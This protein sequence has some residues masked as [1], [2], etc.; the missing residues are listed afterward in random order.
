QRSPPQEISGDLTTDARG[1]ANISVPTD[2][3]DYERYL[4]LQVDARDESGR[5][6]SVQSSVDVEP[7]TFAV[8]LVPRTWFGEVNLPSTVDVSATRYDRRPQ[9]PT[10]VHVRILELH[11]DRGWDAKTTDRGS[12]DV[13][14]GSAG[15]ASFV[16]TP[17]VAGTYRLEATA[18]DEHGNPVQAAQY[19]WVISKDSAWAP[20]V[21]QPQLIPQKALFPAGSPVHVL[22]AQSSAGHDV[23]LL[24]SSDRLIEHR[25]LRDVG[26]TD[27][28]V[29]DP[30]PG[31]QHLSVMAVVPSER[32]IE[33]AQTQVEIDPGPTTLHVAV[34]PSKQRYQPGEPA[35]F[36]LHVT[37]VN[38]KPVRAQIALGVVD[39]GIYAIAPDNA[40][41]RAPFYDRTIYTS[42][43]AGWSPPNRSLKSIAKLASVDVYGVRTGQANGIPAPTPAPISARVR[44]HFVDTAYWAPAV[45]TD[46]HGNA[47]VHF[48]WPDNLTTWVST[49]TAFSKATQI[50][51][52]KTDA[53]VTKDFL[54]RLETPRFLRAGDRAQVTGIAQGQHAGTP[55]RMQLQSPQLD[56]DAEQS[57]VLSA[58]L[59]ASASWP[60]TVPGIGAA[61]ITLRGT[62][63]TLADALQQTLPLLG[64]TPVEHVR[65]AGRVDAVV[66]VPTTIASGQMAGDL[67]LSFSPSL[68]AELAQ[69]LREFNVYPYYCTEQ[70][71]SN[72]LV[73]A[74][75][76]DAARVKGLALPNDPKIVIARARARLDDL[77]HADGGWGW[78]NADP[79]NAFMTAYAVWTLHA[80]DIADLD[81]MQSYRIERGIAWLTHD[82]PT[83]T[84]VDDRDRALALYAIAV[85]RPTE[86]PAH[87]L[88]A[89]FVH[90]EKLGATTVALSGLAA[91]AAGRDDLAQRAA[92]RLRQTALSNG[93]ARFWRDGDWGY[94]WWSDPIAATSYAT[95][96]FEKLH[97]TA[98]VD[99]ALAFLRA[100]RNGDWWYTTADTAAAATA[101]AGAESPGDV[102]HTNETVRVKIGDRVVRTI[103]IASTLPDA[104]ETHIVIPATDLQS[105]EPVTIERSGSGV[106]YWSSD[107]SRYLNRNAT[108][109]KDASEGILKRLFAAP[110]ALAVNRRYTVDHPGPWRVGDEVR[111]DLWISA[112]N[113]AGYVTLEDPFPAGV[114]YQPLQGEGAY[115]SWSGTQF[116]DDRAAFFFYWL[117]PGQT[118]HLQYRLR[119]TTPGTFAAPGPSAYASYGPP[120]STVGTGEEVVIR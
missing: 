55:V 27:D 95:M 50:G 97:D 30:P 88:D 64:G 44:S 1:N 17:P 29:I 66:V 22:L 57:G 52:V 100:Q 31:V 98:D 45:D 107:F 102:A 69:T 118:V 19:Q 46:A 60:V 91:Q 42:A 77:E 111:V 2:H 15:K 25:V 21:E 86:L 28:I 11:W 14:T 116:L 5:T 108:S 114:E 61:D 20:P 85:A 59:R 103:A 96:L 35:S 62:N 51:R 33:R 84:K 67:H 16:W 119:A 78:W 115:A 76:Y 82:L 12:V 3:R 26:L 110:P 53:L 79:S 4:N 80:M 47:V 18:T 10:R 34:D 99:G 73:A 93:G 23:L 41:P 7:A 48:D 105:H 6:I 83:D 43:S 58:T 89:M 101:L 74:A 36:R 71:G 38:G 54:V 39:Q 81:P 117:A 24:I 8:Q 90:V 32:G 37:D 92:A 40:D 106:L 65:D 87:A 70:T 104:S 13:T 49:A 109:T 56:V 75:L 113:G 9:A 94:E 72:G 120:V 112:A 63:G 68:L